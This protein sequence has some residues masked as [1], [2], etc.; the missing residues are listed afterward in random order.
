MRVFAIAAMMLMTSGCL[1]TWNDVREDESGTRTRPAATKEAP[2]APNTPASRF[3]EV[4]EQ[5]RALNGRV[6][7]VESA[8]QQLH[9][10]R[11]GQA[12]SETRLQQSLDQKLQIFEDAIRKIEGQIAQLTEEIAK[13]KEPPPQPAA[14]A[15]GGAKR[16]PYDDGEDHFGAKRWKEAIV[17][18]QKYRDSYPKG[19]MY[20]DATYKIGVCFQELGLKDE[21]IPFFEEVMT[22]FPSS[23]EG[24]KAAYRL[25]SV[26]K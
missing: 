9:S 1:K 22:K 12:D 8:V 21:S 25:K 17:A 19:K 10:S 4:D 6:E 13:L 2:P 20:P 3:E 26:K 16:T 15:S 7:S 23:K 18:Y 24:K 11:Q 14:S 5:M